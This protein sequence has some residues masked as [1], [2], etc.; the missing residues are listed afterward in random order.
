MN[1]PT[2]DKTWVTLRDKATGNHALDQD[3][4]G[5]VPHLLFNL[6]VK[7]TVP[8]E[9]LLTVLFLWD[10]TV[11]TG[12]DCGNCALSQIPVRARDKTRWLAALVEC[13]FW[14]CRKASNRDHVGSFYEYKNP[15]AAE[16]ERFFKVASITRKFSNMDGISPARFGQVFARN[17]AGGG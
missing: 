4:Y 8:D 9:F 5:P 13:G 11:G 17:V 16:W 14:E 6:A 1:N 12:D 15:T 2:G 10:R 3:A 7:Y